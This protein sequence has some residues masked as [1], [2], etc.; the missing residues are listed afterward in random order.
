MRATVTGAGGF[1]G[2]ALVRQL[3]ERGDA[4]R[5]VVRE[6]ARAAHLRELGCEVVGIDLAF[7]TPDALRA[8]VEGSDAVFHL[9]GS[10]RVG[11]PASARPAM[12]AANITA[13]ERVLD[14]ARAAGVPRTVYVSTA[15]V[16]GDT[17][18]RV[19][20]ETYRRPQPPRFLSYYDETKY[21]GH[22]VAE[23][24]IAE[25][26]AVQ[27][28]MPCLVYGPG[29]PSQAGGVIARAMAGRLPVLIGGDL[30]GNFVHV[31]DLVTGILLVHDRGADGESYLLGGEIARMRDVLRRAAEVAGKRPPL[32]ELPSWPARLLAPIA[33]RRAREFIRAGLGVTYWGTD[34]K[35][36]RELGY[37]SRDLDEGLR[38][39]LPA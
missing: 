13:A 15:N 34:A 30:G 39:L 28:V 6:P 9:A 36:R 33:G 24:R 19:V 7:G 1:I 35:A 22:L 11:I 2:G 3:R 17:G 32:L 25:G 26:A 10:Y 21:L 16:L 20:D 37:A 27:I 18:G 4:V 12:A 29:D 5:A 38:T 14:A 31:E 23:Q 8:T